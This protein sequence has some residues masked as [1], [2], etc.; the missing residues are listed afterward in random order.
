MVLISEISLST[1]HLA[2]EKPHIHKTAPIHSQEDSAS[3]FVT[4][5][6]QGF[7]FVCLET[8]GFFLLQAANTSIAL[9]VFD[10][11]LTGSLC[12]NR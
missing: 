6:Q 10:Q 2:M 3:A 1:F 5:S 7:C 4:N 8:H 12:L 11:K 9:N